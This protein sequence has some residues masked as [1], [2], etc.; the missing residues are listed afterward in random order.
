MKR[1]KKALLNY[2]LI[3]LISDGKPKSSV[4]D[5]EE[6][7]ALILN[8]SLSA[9]VK[10]DFYEL[11]CTE[12]SSDSFMKLTYDFFNADSAIK[13]AE[14]CNEINDWIENV[15]NKLDPPVNNYTSEQISRIMAL[16]VSEKAS[17]DAEY[18]DLLCR[19][20][21]VFIEKNGVF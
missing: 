5:I 9:R 17:R 4:D 20:T 2:K 8:S 1:M 10:K 11:I 7:K 15:K 16:I 3:K 6:L 13:N 21:E 12:F 14:K 19:F 18:N